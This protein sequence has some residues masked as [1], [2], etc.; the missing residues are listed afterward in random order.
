LWKPISE[1]NRTVQTWKPVFPPQCVEWEDKWDAW[2]EVED[3]H[4]EK[5]H[6][7]SKNLVRTGQLS[8]PEPEVLYFLGLRLRASLD[9][10]HTMYALNAGKPVSLVPFP[11]IEPSEYAEWLMTEWSDDR[12]ILGDFPCLTSL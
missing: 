2:R 8:R 6:V 7:A 3:Q 10:L 4:M 1:A 9:H 11:P 5:I 12:A